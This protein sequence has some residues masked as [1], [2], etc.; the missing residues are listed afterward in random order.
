MLWRMNMLFAVTTDPV[1]RS[2]AAA[3]SGGWSESFW[4]DKNIANAGGY[5]NYW[6]DRRIALLPKECSV[7]GYRVEQFD[8]A[9][10]KLIPLG[11]SSRRLVLPGGYNGHVDMPQNALQI[12]GSSGGGANTSRF[13]LRGM[14]DEIIV[15]GEYAPDP[16]FLTA[17]RSYINDIPTQG[18]GFVGRDRSLPVGKVNRT[19][20]GT[21]VV[22]L[23]A[24][25]GGVANQSYLR[26]LK[27]RDDS[28]RAIK[29][30]FLITAIAG[31]LYTLQ[32][33][34]QTM[35]KPNGLARVD[36]M[37][38]FSFGGLTVARAIVRKIGRPFESYR[39]RASRKRVA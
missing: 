7:V 19:D 27:A 1:D 3:H 24:N 15:R 36:V 25:I 29:G 21:G 38:F 30:S 5:F 34:T 28:G 17:M 20:G 35:T 2:T 11:A 33:M 22:T 16:A 26:F 6:V 9:G 39:G 10:N 23:S 31:N 4:S 32:N 37:Q 12:S 18:F 14:P 8:I 13:S